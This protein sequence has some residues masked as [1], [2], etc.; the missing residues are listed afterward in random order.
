MKVDVIVNGES[1]YDFYESNG[2]GSQTAHQHNF[3][4]AS[5]LE[6]DDELWL[7]NFHAGTLSNY[8]DKPMTF[9]GYKTN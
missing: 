5:K 8:A 2:G 4:F 1:V 9:V 7:Y 3:I 6:E